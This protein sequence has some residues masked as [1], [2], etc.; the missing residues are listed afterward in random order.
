MSTHNGNRRM[1]GLL[2][3][4]VLFVGLMVGAAVGGFA[5]Y[6]FSQG[7]AAARPISVVQPAPAE[8][9]PLPTPN[10]GSE[11][12]APT[13]PA[14]PTSGTEDPT[15]SAVQRAQPATVRVITNSGSGSGVI[16]SEEGYIVTNNHVVEG[17]RQFAV[18]Y[19][20]G[21][22]I[23]ATL[24]GTAPEFD[25]AVL[26]VDGPVPA[27]VA[28]GDSSALPLGGQVIAIGS[29]LGDY[30]NTVTVGIL[31]G[32]NRSLGNLQGLLQTDAA[33]NHGNSGGPLINRNGEVIGINTMVVRGG[34]SEAEGLGFAIPSNIANGIARQLILTG[35]AERPLMGV[36]LVGLNTQNAQELGVTVSEGAYIQAVT[37]NGPS[38]Q[39]GIQ[40]G[41]VIVA[42]DGRPVNDR[43][44]LQ[45]LVLSHV[46]G[47]T[48]TL[49]ILRGSERAEVQLTLTSPNRLG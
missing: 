9:L 41:D 19:A 25:L 16:I 22:R 4:A 8:E 40:P 30:Q 11:L 21:E 15:V 43:D 48:I 20:R 18:D 28:W 34:Q 1:V 23:P 36:E 10:E 27:V 38:A 3:I 31:S 33:I 17:A 29:A 42:V 37:R 6:I 12:P 45:M 32:V 13:Q 24:V 49:S 35:Q 44:T 14:P 39:A 46:P 26:K 47:D 5:G 2:V 7:Q